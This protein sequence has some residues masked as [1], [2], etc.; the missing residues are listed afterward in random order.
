MHMYMG[1]Y[2][3]KV[4]YIINTNSFFILGISQPRDLQVIANRCTDKSISLS[5]CPPESHC[6]QIKEY[7]LQWKKTGTKFLQIQV[8]ETETIDF[9]L[10][11]LT[12]NTEYHFKVAAII[13]T[14]EDH[15]SY[16][17]SK[18]HG[19]FTDEISYYTSTYVHIYVHTVYCIFYILITD[20]L[21]KYVF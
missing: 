21:F 19:C 15:G 5:W 11:G 6:T 16:S 10:T 12:P 1:I 14:S 13:S 7:V 2:V 3:F 8:K 4:C 20:Y 17:D 18:Y 9:E